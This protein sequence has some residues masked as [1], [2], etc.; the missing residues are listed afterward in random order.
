MKGKHLAQTFGHIKL[1]YPLCK[2]FNI[3]D[4]HCWTEVWGVL[5]V[6][7]L[8][9]ILGPSSLLIGV[10]S[11]GEPWQ[12]WGSSHSFAHPCIGALGK[13]EQLSY[14]QQG[15]GVSGQILCLMNRGACLSN[16]HAILSY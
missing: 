13:L 7:F 8:P 5:T 12:T 3:S 6:P 9:V 10:K 2:N 16:L 14:G 15:F 11:L 1:I 4:K